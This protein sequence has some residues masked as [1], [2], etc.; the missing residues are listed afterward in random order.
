M[1]LTISQQHKIE[2]HTTEEEKR[3]GEGG[4]KDSYQ[5]V[6]HREEDIL[7]NSVKRTRYAAI[8]YFAMDIFYYYQDEP[9]GQLCARRTS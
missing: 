4:K 9:K 3:R 1:S 5:K 6:T 7:Y 8:K 2:L